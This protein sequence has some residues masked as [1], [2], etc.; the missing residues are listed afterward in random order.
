[1]G[2]QQY[3][4][5]KSKISF[6]YYLNVRADFNIGKFAIRP[7]ILFQNLFMEEQEI[8]SFLELAFHDIVY[9]GIGYQYEGF[10]NYVGVTLWEMLSLIYGIHRKEE[11]R[12]IS[13]SRI[14]NQ[15][16]MIS[17]SF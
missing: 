16:V 14:S 11:E 15:Y 2:N 10:L 1:M 4:E 5:D 8:I 3:P 6:K 7:E 9:A 13:T 17:V 12:F